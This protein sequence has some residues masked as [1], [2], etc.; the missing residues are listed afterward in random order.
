[1]LDVNQVSNDLCVLLV[2]LA[3]LQ[4]IYR[5]LNR[6]GAWRYKQGAGSAFWKQGEEPATL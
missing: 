6:G 3:A 4:S 5:A 2:H 1:M